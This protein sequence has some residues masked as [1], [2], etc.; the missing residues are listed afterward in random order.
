[1]TPAVPRARTAKIE[2]ELG[3]FRGFREFD[4]KEA[5]SSVW[6]S[7][8]NIKISYERTLSSLHWTRWR[9]IHIC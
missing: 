2:R 3:Q 8:I 5:T 6:L 1:M 7:Q 4:G 9:E